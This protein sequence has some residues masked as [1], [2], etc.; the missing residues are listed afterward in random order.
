MGCSST[1]PYDHDLYWPIVQRT[2]THLQSLEYYQVPR[3]RVLFNKTEKRI[4][5][6]LDKR[7]C[8]ATIKRMIMAHFHLP[9]AKTIFQTDLH[10]TTAPDELDQ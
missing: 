6:Y 10:N 1:G 7:L 5:A 3:G 2:H 4:Y 8:T 9:R